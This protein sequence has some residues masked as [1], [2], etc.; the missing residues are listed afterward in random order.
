MARG[1]RLAAMFTGCLFLAGCGT[2]VASQ[3]GQTTAPLKM[4]ITSPATAAPTPASSAGLAGS[5]SGQPAPT[6]TLPVYSPK[7]YSPPGPPSALTNEQAQATR[8][9]WESKI[10]QAD[11]ELRKITFTPPTATPA[12]S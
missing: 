8:S 11:T 3:A 12:R 9:A 2:V 1:G 7:P 4:T 5:Q 6:A 10:A